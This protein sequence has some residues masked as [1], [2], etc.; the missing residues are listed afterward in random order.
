MPPP[1]V[2]TDLMNS[3]FDRRDLLNNAILLPAK[4][5]GYVM[6][7]GKILNTLI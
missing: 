4:K 7:E 1:T 6:S 5:Y 3:N 2:Y